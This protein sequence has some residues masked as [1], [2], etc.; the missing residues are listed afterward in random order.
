MK[1]ILTRDGFAIFDEG[2]T[3]VDVARSLYGKPESAGFCDIEGGKPID[4]Y[5]PTVK[6]YGESISLKIPSRDT[7][8]DTLTRRINRARS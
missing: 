5:V 3:H 4:N 7:D 8:S 2:Q 1:Y 6:C